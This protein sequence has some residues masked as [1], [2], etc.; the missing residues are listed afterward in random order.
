MRSGMTEFKRELTIPL[1][2]TTG[3]KKQMLNLN[4][5]IILQKVM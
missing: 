3:G 2:I 1:E 5:Y 4:S